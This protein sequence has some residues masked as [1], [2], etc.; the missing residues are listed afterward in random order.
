M[1]KKILIPL[2]GSPNSNS[3]IQYAVWLGERLKAELIGIHVVD[4]VALEGPFLHDLSGSLGFEPYLNFSSRMR[5][6]LESKGK[7]ILKAFEEECKRATLSCETLLEF[8]IVTNEIVDRAKLAD[9]VILGRRGMNYAFDD[10]LLG[11]VTE[12]VIRRSPRPVM[13]VPQDFA[14]IKNPLLLY[15]GSFNASKAMRSAVEL[16]KLLGLRLTALTISRKKG[17]GEGILQEVK[18]YAKP[19]GI[20][21]QTIEM[22]GDLPEDIVTYWEDHDHDL[23]FMGVTS[24]TRIVEMVLGSTAEFVMRR[25]R[26]P[27]FLER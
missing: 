16:C 27:I 3:A 25:I 17:E 5:E 22:V 19:Y 6:I 9:L 7:D 2:D 11:S 14:K 4:V 15:D 1:F 23:L 18:E 8:G 20:D 21:L 24:H 10:G 13:V 12:G 26:T